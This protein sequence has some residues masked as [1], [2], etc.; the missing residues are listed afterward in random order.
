MPPDE[1]TRG[2][3]AS[4]DGDRF[5][6]VGDLFRKACDLPVSSR[7]SFLEAACPDDT[8]IRREVESLLDH[9]D[10]RPDAFEQG[11]SGI[12]LRLLTEC[13]ARASAAPTFARRVCGSASS[14]A[15]RARRISAILVPDPIVFDQSSAR[16][17]VALVGR[18]SGFTSRRYG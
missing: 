10:D 18:K 3:A 12:G 9:D 6:R 8:G 17:S 11:G 7:A 15:S 2:G 14:S 1:G 13:A 16:P 5:R 4:R